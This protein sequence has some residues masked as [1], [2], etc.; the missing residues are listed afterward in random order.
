[1]YLLPKRKKLKS[2]VT[3]IFNVNVQNSNSTF[4][5]TIELLRKKYFTNLEKAYFTLKTVNWIKLL[6][7]P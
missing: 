3:S 4:F 6:T 7:M 1:M 2:L 5:L